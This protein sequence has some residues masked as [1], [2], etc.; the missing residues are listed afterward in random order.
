M[1]SGQ[2]IMTHAG[3][4]IGGQRVSMIEQILVSYIVAIYNAEVTLPHCLDSLI[5]QT[6]KELEI[7]LLNDGST[8]S[9]ASICEEYARKDP[10]IRV[11]HQSNKGVS[12]TRQRGL[13]EARGKYVIHADPDDWVESDT[14]SQMV[15]YAEE[16]QTDILISDFW[17][18]GPGQCDLMI[19]KP[20]GS[21]T[22]SLIRDFFSHI[23]GSCCNKLIKKECCANI[24]FMPKDISLGED[25]LFIV[26]VLNRNIKISYINNAYYHYRRDNS[27]SICSSRNEH[28]LLSRMK[29]I[30]EYEKILDKK[31]YNNFFNIKRDVLISLFVTKNLKQLKYTYKEIH[32]QI[33]S[34][35]KRYS[36]RLPLGYFFPMG[37][38]SNP[39]IAY[40][41]YK[42]HMIV[43]NT[44]SFTKHLLKSRTSITTKA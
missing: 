12:Y 40:Y 26:R 2:R 43:F 24:K 31:E 1:D 23:H 3:H 33:I 7:I 4:K 18:N 10:R 16:H 8:D 44:F 29:V 13:D 22:S 17:F 39:Y 37:L 9:S 32:P 34:T 6:H 15:A 11:L 30:E 21:T 42:L 28:I 14:L 25:E 38:K 41:L 27:D 5:N 36:F 19:Q 20:S 35:Q